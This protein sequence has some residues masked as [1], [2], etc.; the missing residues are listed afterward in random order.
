MEKPNFIKPF[1]FCCQRV[2]PIVYD[3]SLSDYEVL[4]K[5]IAKLNEVIADQNALNA[6][7]V[8]YKAALTKE[9][10]D[11]QTNLT[12]E[13]DVYQ[14]Q[15]NQSYKDFTD[16]INKIVADL[17]AWVEGEGLQLAVDNK[18][19]EWLK[20]GT[21]DNI[22]N[23]DIFGGIRDSIITI[24][25]EMQKLSNT[26]IL[27]TSTNVITMNMLTQEVK[28]ALTGGS[29]P[30]V[31]EG[32]VGTIN[33]QNDAVTSTQLAPLASSVYN[34]T[35]GNS[36][37][38]NIDTA[39][40]TIT[41]PAG[42]SISYSGH[43][44]PITDA[45]TI[46]IPEAGRY[47]V[48]ERDTRTYSLVTSFGS[49]STEGYAI[50]GRID[51]TGGTL[52]SV[53]IRPGIIYTVD[54]KYDILRFK[55]LDASAIPD[56]SLNWNKLS[57]SIVPIYSP[58]TPTTNA[59]NVNFTNDTLEI[60]ALTLYVGNN[61]I[62]IPASDALPLNYNSSG[63]SYIVLDIDTKLFSSVTTVTNTTTQAFIMSINKNNQSVLG[64]KDIYIRVNGQRPIE[65][66]TAV[67]S[68]GIVSRAATRIKQ[69]QG[70][71]PFKWWGTTLPNIDTTAYT[72][73]F[74]ANQ[75]FSIANDIFNLSQA[76]T[77]NIRTGSNYFYYDET[78]NQIVDGTVVE[79]THFYF[80]WIYRNASTNSL[81][82]DFTSDVSY[83]VD[84]QNDKKDTVLYTFYPPKGNANDPNIAVSL[85]V[86]TNTINVPANQYIARNGSYG[87]LPGDYS[88]DN[89][90]PN[91]MHP[92]YL[93]GG[94][95]SILTGNSTRKTNIQPILGDVNTTALNFKKIPFGVNGNCLL[96]FGDSILGSTTYDG[97]KAGINCARYIANSMGIA[98]EWKMAVGGASFTNPSNMLITQL[99]N[100]KTVMADNPTVKPFAVITLAGVNDFRRNAPMGTK[101]T[102][103]NTT[104]YYRVTEFYTAMR[105]T[106]YNIPVA[107]C[108]PFP[109]VDQNVPNA[110]GL[111]FDDYI[112][113][114]KE[115]ALD[116]LNFD[117]IDLRK[118]AAFDITNA[119]QRAVMLPDGLHPSTLLH[120]KV[121]PII[122]SHIVWY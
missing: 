83:T 76:Q 122:K 79:P 49:A 37:A 73:T 113:V 16:N 36:Y 19:D 43:L 2:L 13:W 21:I 66:F 32:A 88:I 63:Y 18:L 54:G 24:Q 87:V 23:Q 40:K 64:I 65:Y 58:F 92:I 5:V 17:K 108:T 26:A 57:Q 34:F 70:C 110:L 42:Y 59:L 119:A 106:F 120:A 31:G 29:T 109:Y 103:D 101:G 114:M 97:T 62:S 75:V 6:A 118:Y 74:P 56:E 60:P 39:A 4:C 25:D 105:D 95:L 99:N 91:T 30:V 45:Q 53:L 8:E 12:G 47:L 55:T 104:F 107:Y 46:E 35:W 100:A 27:K 117:L 9:W 38:F 3:D 20:D 22:I 52:Q 96:T 84:G 14:A 41:F 67:D 48:F 51:F 69:P 90:A 102:T 94:K 93:N 11:Y 89:T 44:Y 115:I 81:I 72:I 7:W 77:I 71:V 61:P 15:M 86:S 116:V 50:L 121:A 1:Q 112:N 28:T 80:A 33:I 98:A 82:I 85:D 10:E 111:I 68:N 78:T